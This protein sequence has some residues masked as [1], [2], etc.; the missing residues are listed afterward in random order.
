MG[1]NC[2]VSSKSINHKWVNG[3]GHRSDRTDRRVCLSTDNKAR[4]EL[5]GAREPIMTMI[6]AML[7]FCTEYGEINT[8]EKIRVEQRR[9]YDG[10]QPPDSSILFL[11][12][13][14]SLWRIHRDWTS[15]HGY[16]RTLPGYRRPS[17]LLTSLE[18]WPRQVMVH[19]RQLW[20]HFHKLS[21]IRVNI[22]KRR[23]FFK[24]LWKK[25]II[26]HKE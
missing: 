3:Q 11:L 6:T 25:R 20:L 12:N 21:L 23:I 10:K 16:N 24:Q 15:C 9:T 4:L 13:T 26:I 17:H 2:Q 1:H 19:S 5:S 18:H 14:T 7:A 8:W 22:F